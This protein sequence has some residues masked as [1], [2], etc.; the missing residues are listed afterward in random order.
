MA[1][2]LVQTRVA[3]VAFRRRSAAPRPNRPTIIMAQEAGSG[4][5]VR[6]TLSSRLP[7]WFDGPESVNTRFPAVAVVKE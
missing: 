6:L 3:A 2:L 7:C 5:A 1:G 4:T